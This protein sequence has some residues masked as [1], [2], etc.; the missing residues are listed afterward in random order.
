ME[1]GFREQLEG[2]V[3]ELLG[4]GLVADFEQRKEELEAR[5]IT[6]HVCAEGVKK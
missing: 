1:R 2:E 5:M 6:C 3:E 4:N